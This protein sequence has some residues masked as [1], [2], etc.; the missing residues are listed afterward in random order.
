MGLLQE[1]IAAYTD[2]LANLIT[3][4]KELDELRERVKRAKKLSTATTATPGLLDLAIRYAGACDKRHQ[5][6]VPQQ[7]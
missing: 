1:R 6:S 2:A 5:R 4:L 7:H 3:Q